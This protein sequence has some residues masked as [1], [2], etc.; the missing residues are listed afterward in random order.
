MIMVQYSQYNERFDLMLKCRLNWAYIKLK[1]NFWVETGFYS[2]GSW[3]IYDGC[4]LW[5]RIWDWGTLW[6]RLRLR[7]FGGKLQYLVRFKRHF[8]RDFHFLNVI[9]FQKKTFFKLLSKKH[10]TLK[11]RIR[12]LKN[13]TI[14]AQD[15]IVYQ[16]EHKIV[17]PVCFKLFSL[18]ESRFWIL[19]HFLTIFIFILYSFFLFS[20][21]LHHHC[22]WYIL[23][24][25]LLLLLLL[26]L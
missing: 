14:L 10:K 19:I 4:P 20:S 1:L 17:I 7:L 21:L 24:T 12:I 8:L 11:T 25:A 18:R 3:W 23:K 16:K 15:I 22:I 6:R 2:S 9:S 5:W 26:I 13:F